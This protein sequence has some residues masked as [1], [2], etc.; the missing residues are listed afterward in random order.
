[1]LFSWWGTDPGCSVLERGQ[2]S[3]P[4]AQ[5]PPPRL[6]NRPRGLTSASFLLEDMGSWR[7]DSNGGDH[8]KVES[9]PGEHGTDFPDPQVKKY[10][11]TSYG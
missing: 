7:I 2:A 3:S 5:K 10:F 11:V 6:G 8:W 9:L 4:L 1:M